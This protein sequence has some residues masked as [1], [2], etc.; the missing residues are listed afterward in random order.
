MHFFSSKLISYNSDFSNQISAYF[1][2]EF[3]YTS[4]FFLEI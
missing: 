2:L 4:D 1:L 3:I